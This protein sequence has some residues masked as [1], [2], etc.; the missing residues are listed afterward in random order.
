MVR[1]FDKGYLGTYAV[2]VGRIDQ[3]LMLHMEVANR[4][5][6]AGVVREWFVR[7][8]RAMKRNQQI[9]SEGGLKEINSAFNDYELRKRFTTHDELQREVA[10]I[11][12]KHR[13]SSM[14]PQ[15]LQGIGAINA[16]KHK[17]A[18]AKVN[19]AIESMTLQQSLAY[20][21]SREAMR[22]VD[23]TVE[24]A[25]AD[26]ESLAGAFTATRQAMERILS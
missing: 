11:M 24:Q 10:S 26:R 16:M 3:T 22:Q 5:K 6:N 17:K 2:A 15:Q 13:R 1:D 9:I 23:A 12:V 19:P 25:S 7:E 14:T 21:G 18:L 4:N 8:Y 20:E